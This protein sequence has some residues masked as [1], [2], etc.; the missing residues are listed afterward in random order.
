MDRLDRIGDPIQSV[1]FQLDLSGSSYRL[2]ML[3]SLTVDGQY[4]ED[5][6]SVSSN[7]GI[8]ASKSPL[9]APSV[10]VADSLPLLGVIVWHKIGSP[11]NVS[12]L[13][14][15][16]TADS[17]DGTKPKTELLGAFLVPLFN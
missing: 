5:L 8:L 17:F 16:R 10:F 7:G 2:K 9:L 4:P 14:A 11:K 3:T 12:N 6:A 15:Y 13:R 1:Q